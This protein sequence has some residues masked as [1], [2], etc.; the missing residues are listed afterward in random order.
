M[1]I[2]TGIWIQMIDHVR[3]TDDCFFAPIISRELPSYDTLVARFYPQTSNMEGF[4]QVNLPEGNPSYDMVTES[5][6]FR[7]C[8]ILSRAIFEAGSASTPENLSKS[9]ALEELQNQGRC[10]WSFCAFEDQILADTIE[11]QV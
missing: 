7:N 2:S 3:H 8:R 5:G 6:M 1:G 9:V 4:P 11:N 10:R